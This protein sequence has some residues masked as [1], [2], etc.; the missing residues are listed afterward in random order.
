MEDNIQIFSTIPKYP[1]SKEATITYKSEDGNIQLSVF[2]SD[3][4]VW[5]TQQQMALLF[6]SSKQNINWHIKNIF[7]EGELDPISTVKDYLTVQKEGNREVQRNL[8]L[9]NLDV[10]ISVGYRVKSIQGTKFR[11]WANHVLKEYLLKGYCINEHINNIEQR[12]NHQLK[13]I[14]L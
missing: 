6:H 11:M 4:T 14:F 8:M 12:I 10:I 13:L 9:Y 3:D 5:L 7:K 2:L 1:T